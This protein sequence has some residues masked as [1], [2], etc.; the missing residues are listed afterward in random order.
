M[1]FNR[2]NFERKVMATLLLV[3]SK[4][5]AIPSSSSSPQSELLFKSNG[6]GFVVRMGC[7]FAT[8]SSNSL[9]AQYLAMHIRSN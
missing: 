8:P 1:L 4:G 7:I 3:N 6:A 9:I 5:E 2:G